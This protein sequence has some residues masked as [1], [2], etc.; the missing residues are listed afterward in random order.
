MGF[1]WRERKLDFVMAP[2]RKDSMSIGIGAI[3][4]KTPP[5]QRF[6]VYVCRDGRRRGVA[7]LRVRT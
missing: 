6:V 7:V 2:K 5:T 3:E 1:G 4:A